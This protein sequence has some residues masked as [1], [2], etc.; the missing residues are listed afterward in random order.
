FPSGGIPLSSAIRL[1]NKEIE[2]ELEQE[3][4]KASFLCKNRYKY[5]P[6]RF[7]QMLERGGPIKTAVGLVM[8]PTYHEGFTKLWQLGRLDL[9]VEAIILQEPYNQL[10]SQEILNTARSKLEKIGYKEI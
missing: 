4:L 5:N 9:T 3:F 2:K 7:L 1:M 8:A 10:L 6:T